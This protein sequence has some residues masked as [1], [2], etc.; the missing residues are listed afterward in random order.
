MKIASNRKRHATEQTQ[1]IKKRTHLSPN[2]TV[3]GKRSVMIVAVGCLI[4]LL[5]TLVPACT[6]GEKP[7]QMNAGETTRIGDFRWSVSSVLKT[8]EIGPQNE[9]TKATGSFIITGMTVRNEVKKKNEIDPSSIELIDSKERIYKPDKNLTAAYLKQIE[10]DKNKNI[11][12]TKF[13]PLEKHIIYAVFDVKKDATD[14][15][16]IVLASKTG[17]EQDVIFKVGF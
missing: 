7:K 9:K 15:S 12:N 6:S 4:A 17:A 13:L 16:L 10:S 1:L 11:Y 2:H 3:L 5:L 8:Q 14:L